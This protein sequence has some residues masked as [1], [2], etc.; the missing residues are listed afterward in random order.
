M[1]IATGT[2]I[3]VLSVVGIGAASAFS[4]SAHSSLCNRPTSTLTP[5]SSLL[6]HATA[7][8]NEDGVIDLGDDEYEEVEP[9]KMRVS[10]IKAELK[11]RN[12]D[13]SDC[14][15]KESLAARLASARM[16]GKADPSLVDDFKQRIEEKET[17]DIDDEVLQ[18]AVGGDG[19]LPG[20]M[21]PDMLRSL[22]SNPELVELL[23]SE[24]MQG[25]MKLMMTEGQ[26]GMQKAMEEDQEVYE[27]VM[28]LNKVMG[29]SQ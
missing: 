28:K 3:V 12:V 23:Q 24:K 25:V 13:F 8:A 6:L 22:M 2:S 21:P 4:P 16:Q 10:E 17:I 5:S 20:G 26:E 7:S 15:E 14:F 29:E 27:L 9:G 11:L 18:S 19:T 1:K